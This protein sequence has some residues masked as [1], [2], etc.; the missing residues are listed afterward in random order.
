M[1][2]QSQLQKAADALALAGAAELDRSPGA[3]ARARAAIN[4]LLV[5]NELAGMETI[6]PVQL[7]HALTDNDFYSVI[8]VASQFFTS[9]TVAPD[10]EH[11]RFVGVRVQAV[12]LSAIFPVSF[13]GGATNRYTAGAS[14]VAGSDLVSCKPVPMFICN[15]FETGGGTPAPN[16]LIRLQY[17]D[18]DQYAPGNFGW[19][20]TMKQGVDY[21]GVADRCGSGNQV[22][23]ALAQSTP[24]ACGRISNVVTE[25]GNIAVADDAINTRFDLYPPGSF[26]GCGT[27]LRYG[28]ASN[29]RK[30][31][32]PNPGN[33]CRQDPIYPK[34]DPFN[35]QLLG[36]D[37]RARGFPLDSN[38]ITATGTPDT[39]VPVGTGTWACADRPLPATNS[40][41]ISSSKVQGQDQI[42][43]P[44]TST[45]GVFQ[46]MAVNG[47]GIPTG[48]SVS[49]TPNVIGVTSTSVTIAVPS[50][51]TVNAGQTIN[52]QGYWSTAHPVGTPGN[53][54]PPVDST[55]PLNVKRC[56]D[57]NISRDFVYNYEIDNGL[58]NDTLTGGAVG[59]PTCGTASPNRDR[60]YMDVAVVNCNAAGPLQG[61]EFGLH[62]IAIWK[63]FLSTP[64]NNNKGPIFGEYHSTEPPPGPGNP[65]F[66]YEV[67]L[68]R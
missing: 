48:T 50:P 52:F 33:A 28:P 15:P 39:S 27:D 24:P 45:A 11:A 42:T 31:Y 3:R 59:G 36:G 64:V 60:R 19:L 12:S 22:P 23:Q 51:V 21:A 16:K 67:Q 4:A 26:N 8:P 5:R 40:T 30:G 61:K 17:A 37:Y 29:V 7:D 43:L 58:L 55:D 62:P 35:R 25:T 46:G 6:G 47:G 56:A 68:Y 54:I 65:N 14:A 38:M 44:F 9:G 20:D 49:N 63:F 18:N 41:P 32:L 53:S 10:D 13:L 34:N 57:N 2:L 1:S 66:F